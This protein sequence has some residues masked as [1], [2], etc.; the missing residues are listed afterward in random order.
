MSQITDLID[1][2]KLEELL[3]AKWS[4]FVNVSK[5]FEFIETNVK[6]R[7][8]SFGVINDTTI[9]IKNKQLMLSRFQLTSQGFIVWVEFTVP[10][11]IGIATGT[12]EILIAPKG[13]ITHIQTLGNIYLPDNL[14]QRPIF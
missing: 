10:V 7:K 12:T 14:K 9:K 3:I 4:Q 6:E 11:D 13:I 8:N 1:T 5:L 2:E